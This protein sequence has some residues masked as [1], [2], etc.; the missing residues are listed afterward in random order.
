MKSNVKTRFLAL[1]VVA[2]AGACGAVEIDGIAAKVNS[3]VIL[4]SDVILEM[5][6]AGLSADRYDAVLKEMIERKLILKAA[7]ESKMTMQEWVVENRIREIIQ[8]GFGGDRNK[9]METLAQQKI[10]YPEWRQRMLD[11]MI[12]SA[13]R[14][15]V[16]DKNMV[17]SPAAMRE[18]YAKNPER[19]MAG[20]TTT[21]SVI[22][23][24]PEDAD[25][26]DEVAEALKSESFADVARRYSSDSRA[27]EGGVWKDIVPADVF[28]QEVCKEIADMPVGTLSGWIDLDGWSFLL[29]KDDDN[30][31]RQLSFAEA[32]DDIERNVREEM[33][34][35]QYDRWMER[36]MSESYIKVM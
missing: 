13:M 4:K 18:E 11:D 28:R 34:L 26:R 19:Y 14:W 7:S 25:K 12:V 16:V 2:I 15:Q 27:A 29:R 5:R 32:Y 35:E 21:I 10:S 3:S 8:R 20:G 31:L 17:A 1:C 22:L 33:A 30:Q 36:L 24:K 6:R 9:L 23:L